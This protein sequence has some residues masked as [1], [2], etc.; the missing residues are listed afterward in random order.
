MQS[1]I[2]ELLRKAWQKRGED[3]HDEVRVLLRKVL[4]LCEEE[5]YDT[6][7]R[8]YHIFMQLEYDQE[9]LT[10]ALELSSKSVSY[11]KK[12]NNPDRIAHATRHMADLQRHLNLDSQSEDS[13]RYAID[14]YR[15]IAATRRGDLANALRGF[16]LVLEKRGK[17]EA[18][19]DT[20][21][22]VKALYQSLGLE[23]GVDEA[24]ERLADLQ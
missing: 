8:I 15:E 12:A 7:G 16:A 3:K 11:Y 9:N 14:I 2:S 6:L 21:G 4:E 5:D 1:E 17:V 24:I 10:E 18:A 20:W 13:Y 23:E 19:I 22:E